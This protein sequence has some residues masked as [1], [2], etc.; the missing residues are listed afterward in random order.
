MGSLTLSRIEDEVWN[1]L[2]A[3]SFSLLFSLLFLEFSLLFWGFNWVSAIPV[4]TICRLVGKDPTCVEDNTERY[5][6]L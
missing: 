5:Y 1:E 2:E 6:I 4:S 3:S